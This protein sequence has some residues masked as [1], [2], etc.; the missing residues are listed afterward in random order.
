MT[1][2][3]KDIARIAGLHKGTVSRAL[4]GGFQVSPSTQERVRLLAEQLGYRPNVNAQTLFTK[5]I[6]DVGVIVPT[7]FTGFGPL[8]MTLLEGYWLKAIHGEL[9]ERHLNMMV[10]LDALP[11]PDDDGALHLPKMVAEGHVNGLIVVGYVTERLADGLRRIRLPLVVLDAPEIPGVFA[12][13][14]DEEKAIVLVVEHLVSLG[15]RRI[16]FIN[17]SRE[18]GFR[19]RLFP[20]GYARAMSEAGLPLYPGWDAYRALDPA[21]RDMWKRAERPT[22]VIVQHDED[23][24]SLLQVLSRMGVRVPED[25]SLASAEATAAGQF[26]APRLT[27]V[28]R[29]HEAMARLAVDVLVGLIRGGDK[30]TQMRQAFDPQLEIGES[31]TAPKSESSAAEGCSK[32]EGG[33]K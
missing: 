7:R 8:E 11:G 18:A 13:N 23:A 3:I 33:L 22:A 24:G 29:P 17:E 31:T 25:V 26:I 32:E 28:V 12:V 21:F 30:P 20:R 2:T 4:H 1:V 14:A 9:E 15:H 27:R 6:H 5:A 10:S 19:T 16:A